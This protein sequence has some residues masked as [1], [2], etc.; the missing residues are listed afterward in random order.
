MCKHTVWSSLMIIKRLDTP[1]RPNAPR[2]DVQVE[3][4]IE[5]PYWDEGGLAMTGIY[6]IRE[7]A[8]V[9]PLPEQVGEVEADIG[10]ANISSHT[11]SR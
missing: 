11:R 4:L 8:P 7:S 10:G 3:R 1:P 5:K 6:F 2:S 9:V